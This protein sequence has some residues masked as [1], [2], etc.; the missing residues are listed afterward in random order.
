MQTGRVQADGLAR[1]LELCLGRYVFSSAA[2]LSIDAAALTLTRHYKSERCAQSEHSAR[3]A[4]VMPRNYNKT[5]A[6]LANMS[7]ETG[8]MTFS[9]PNARFLP[10]PTSKYALRRTTP[11]TKPIIFGYLMTA[12]FCATTSAGFRYSCPLNNSAKLPIDQ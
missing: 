9:S 10:T 3:S 7:L 2:P 6:R 1:H 11:T 12:T 5:R 8:D 4:R